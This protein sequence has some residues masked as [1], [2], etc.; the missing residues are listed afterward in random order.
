MRQEK[1]ARE[2]IENDKWNGKILI[3]QIKGTSVS[4]KEE[5]TYEGEHYSIFK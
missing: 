5:D 3:G 4:I 1:L 2:F